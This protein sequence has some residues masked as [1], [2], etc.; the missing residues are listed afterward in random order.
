VLLPIEKGEELGLG[1]AGQ[2]VGCHDPA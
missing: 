2:T 1:H